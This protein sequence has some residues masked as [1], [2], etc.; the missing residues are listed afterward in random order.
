[1]DRDYCIEMFFAVGVERQDSD[2][3][4]PPPETLDYCRTN[5][6][7]MILLV[8]EMMVML[9]NV[10]DVVVV[11]YERTTLQSQ[12]RIETICIVMGRFRDGLVVIGCDEIQNDVGR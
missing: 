9:D 12:Y 2:D 10:R 8:T 4:V 11:G 5:L 7:L 1:M 3:A 6:T